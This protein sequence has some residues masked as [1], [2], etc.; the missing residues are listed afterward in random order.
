MTTGEGGMILTNSE[1][2]YKKIKLLRDHG[3]SEEKKYYHKCV[4][5][6]YRMTSMQAAIGIGQL[7][8][9]KQILNIKNNIKKNYYK[10]LDRKNF[11]I[12]PKIDLHKS[13]NWFVTLSFKKK[14]LR[15]NFIKY[16]KNKKIE[17][18]PMI[19]P[20]SFADQF[21][22]K[23]GQKLFPNS[24]KISLNSVHLPSSLNLNKEKIKH[25]CQIINNW[26]YR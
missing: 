19:F 1:K 11:D 9:L 23:N 22:K 21:K 3:M 16:M 15:N 6:N 24:Y 12:F 13:V 8:R 7:E 18:R 14:N 2:I 10:F 20:I 5:F 17:C 25:I 26:N 4:A